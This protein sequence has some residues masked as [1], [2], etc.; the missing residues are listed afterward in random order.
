M[1][2]A[3]AVLWYRLL[4]VGWRLVSPPAVAAAAVGGC[5]G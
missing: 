2:A 3:A 5:E 4:L 1:D